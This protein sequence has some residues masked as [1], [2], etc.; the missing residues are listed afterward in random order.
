MHIQPPIGIELLIAI[1]MNTQLVASEVTKSS[2][3]LSS[4]VNIKC[5]EM[6]TVSI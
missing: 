6:A 2:A 5:M 1:K 3:E 4:Y